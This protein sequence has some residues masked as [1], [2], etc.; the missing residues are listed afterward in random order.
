MTSIVAIDESGN[1]GSEDRYFIMSAVIARRVRDLKPAFK[2]IDEVRNRRKNP[3]TECEI[4]FYTS[5]ADE[6]VRILKAMVLCPMSIAY[7]CIDKE[8]E[9]YERIRGKALYRSAVNLIM[10]LV[11]NALQTRDVT[12]HYDQNLSV[13]LR[14]LTEM[15]IAGLS[16]CNVKVVKK[17]Q[18]QDNKCVQLADFVAGSIRTRYEYGDS[19]FADII[20][21]KVSFAHEP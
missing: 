16:K 21:E 3:K 1:L 8:S 19:S 6:K 2:E 13:N 18:S 14:E 12:L 11:N 7:V 15:T 10:P 5:Y 17:V 20:S 9:Q 4:K